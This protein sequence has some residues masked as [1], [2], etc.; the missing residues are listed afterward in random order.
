MK[1]RALIEIVTDEFES[2]AAFAGQHSDASILSVDGHSHI[3]TC[4]K[5][6]RLIFENEDF[7]E[8]NGNAEVIIICVD[9][10]K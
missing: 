6:D 7:N 1:I 2:V 5:C 9:C 10:A 8:S 3:A 4:S